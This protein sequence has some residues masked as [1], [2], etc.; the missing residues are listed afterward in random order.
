MDG[1]IT[2]KRGSYERYQSLELDTDTIYFCEDCGRIFVG[3]IEYCP[4]VNWNEVYPINSVI[5]FYDNKDHSNHLG[6]TWEKCLI[7][8]VPVGID[9]NDDSFNSIGAKIGSKTHSL[10]ASELPELTQDKV[11]L[12]IDTSGFHVTGY[13]DT[14]APHNN[15]QPSEVVSFW[16]R[17]N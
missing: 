1:K 2:L 16:R 14:S 10:V 4:P 13:S 12:G 17:I 9:E 11:P 3:D 7:G 15:I 8:R 6:L 5:I